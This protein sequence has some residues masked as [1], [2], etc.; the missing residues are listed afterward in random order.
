VS[1]YDIHLIDLDFALQFC[2]RYRAGQTVAQMLG[3][4]LRIHAAQTEFVSDLQVEMFNP[5]R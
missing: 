4:G 2:G 5:I 1:G 3:H